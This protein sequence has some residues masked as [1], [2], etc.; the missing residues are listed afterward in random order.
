MGKK[1]SSDAFMAGRYGSGS[2]V[3]RI[4]LDACFQA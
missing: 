1:I 2:I 4:D 3:D